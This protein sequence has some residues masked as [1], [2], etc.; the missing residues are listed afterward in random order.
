MRVYAPA[1]GF[2]GPLWWWPEHAKLVLAWGNAFPK[3][4]VPWGGKGSILT[5]VDSEPL[6]APKGSARATL[7]MPKAHLIASLKAVACSTEHGFSEQE[8]KALGLS[9]HSEH[10]SPSDMMEFMGM[11]CPF[12]RFSRF[13]VREAGH[14][15]RL[16]DLE[17]AEEGCGTAEQQKRRR[18]V[19]PGP[20][21][22][23]SAGANVSNACEARYCEGDGRL[24]RR[25]R[26]LGVRR[27]WRLAVRE[28]LMLF[29]APWHELPRSREDWQIL[30]PAEV[31]ADDAQE[32]P[33]VLASHD[34]P[35]ELP[36][37]S[38]LSER[39]I[40]QTGIPSHVVAIDVD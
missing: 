23:L 29:G 4:R 6:A 31:A 40:A 12:G 25:G 35:D 18:G 30:H 38:E 15:L 20:Q 26:Q 11:D 5:V 9:A 2:L 7:V 36:L 27:R 22:S 37:I 1:E 8:F 3:W 10:G 14:W 24:G 16:R 28:A 21:H 32:T 13:D 19:A 33:S 17:E 39:E 34:E